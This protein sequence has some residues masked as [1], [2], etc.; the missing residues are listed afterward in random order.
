MVDRKRAEMR[1][2][3]AA[4]LATI[5]KNPALISLMAT[6]TV[7]A[8]LD[9]EMQIQLVAMLVIVAQR[10]GV[11]Q[12]DMDGLSG[13]SQSS[14]SRNVHALSRYRRDGLPGFGLVEQRPDAKDVRSQRLFLTVAGVAFV[15]RPVEA[16]TDPQPAQA[17]PKPAIDAFAGTHWE[18]WVD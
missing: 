1:R 18:V 12:R 9:N 16:G 13:F 10:P 11:Y 14:V 8:S 7:L 17:M 4:E 3:T 15:S 2:T 6:L 5:K